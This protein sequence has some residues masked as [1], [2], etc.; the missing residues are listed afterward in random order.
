MRTLI[1]AKEAKQV[2]ERVDK[3]SSALFKELYD[4]VAAS[5][6]GIVKHMQPSGVVSN[7]QDRKKLTMEVIDGLQSGVSTLS[8]QNKTE[9]LL[10]TA[11]LIITGVATGGAA[12]VSNPAAVVTTLAAGGVGSL[13]IIKMTQDLV[14]TNS[15][16]RTQCTLHMDGL[17]CELTLCQTE[18]EIL[19]VQK[20]VLKTWNWYKK[21]AGLPQS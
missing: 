17:K 19:E 9:W 5:K 7:I 1:R 6:P 3:T 12:V 13:G 4:Q 10:A 2:V 8:K 21:R 14:K 16:L 20:K 11:S 15:Q 18:D